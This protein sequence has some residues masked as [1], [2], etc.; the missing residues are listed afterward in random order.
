V[1]LACR[2]RAVGYVRPFHR[3]AHKRASEWRRPPCLGTDGSGKVAARGS[4]VRRFEV[5]DSV[6]AYS[7]DNPEGGFYAEF[8]AVAVDV[9]AHKPNRLGLKEAGAIPIIGLT[10]LPGIGLGQIVT[11]VFHALGAATVAAAKQTAF[12]PSA[13]AG[14]TG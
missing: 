6:Y 11:G 8:V 7:W 9:A 12:V 14:R 4:R 5:G 3:V 13:G 10:S 1:S 2:H